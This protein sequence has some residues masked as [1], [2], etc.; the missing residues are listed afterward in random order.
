MPIYET[1][2]GVVAGG[3]EPPHASGKPLYRQVQVGQ[4]SEYI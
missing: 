3:V 2:G 4:Q 1:F